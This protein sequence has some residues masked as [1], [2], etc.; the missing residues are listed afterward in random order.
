MERIWTEEISWIQGRIN[1]SLLMDHK[2]KERLCTVV[3]H[4]EVAKIVQEYLDIYT[5]YEKCILNEINPEI[6]QYIVR[7][8]RWIEAMEREAEKEEVG[9]ALNSIQ[10]A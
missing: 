8:K 1:D 10:Y 3:I 4:P 6:E 5:P 9:I 7:W 2:I